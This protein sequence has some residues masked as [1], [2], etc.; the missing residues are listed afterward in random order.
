MSWSY[1][2]TDLDETTASGRLN[3]V[4]LL[5]GDTDTLDQQVQNEEVTFALLTESNDVYGAAS[6]VAR[7]LAAKYSRFVDV[8]LDG[9]VAESYSQLKD[10]Y[11]LLA[12]KLDNQKKSDG[13]YIGFSAGGIKKS[14]MREAEMDTD[15]VKPLYRRRS[16]EYPCND[17]DESYGDYY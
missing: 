17:P 7:T 15:R 16:Y 6:W 9:Q 1:D 5:V 12:E 11:T 14:K 8:D 13:V 2:V 3:V 10:H 4:R